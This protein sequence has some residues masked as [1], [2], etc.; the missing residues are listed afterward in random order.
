MAS[1]YDRFVRVHPNI[2]GGVAGV[3]KTDITDLGG[4]GGST[5]TVSGIY[6]VDSDLNVQALKLIDNNVTSFGSEYITNGTTETLVIIGENFTGSTE[7][8]FGAGV[9]VNTVVINSPT[10]ATVNITTSTAGNKTV[11]ASTF[12]DAAGATSVIKAMVSTQVPGD[13]TTAWENVVGATVGEG[14]LTATSGTTTWDNG[15]SFGTVPS[16]GDYF[17]E[18]NVNSSGIQKSIIGMAEVY[19]N[20]SWESIQYGLYFG[21]ANFAI[22]PVE[23]GVVGIVLGV[24]YATGDRMSIRRSAGIVRAYKNNVLIHTY[25][26]ASSEASLL[27][28]ISVR[29]NGSYSNIVLRY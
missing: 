28:K 29:D 23:N 25:A 20:A 9:T 24:S 4:G 14:T 13:G 15:A 16:S 19:T 11:Q 6:Y 3:L 18:F 10:Q 17:F 7:F 27:S 8:D 21:S 12:G 22:N 1:Q 5:P 26:D 2:G